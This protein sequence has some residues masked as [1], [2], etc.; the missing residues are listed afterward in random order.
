MDT[1][2]EVEK[3]V[4]EAEKDLSNSQTLELSG[5]PKVKEDI[6]ANTTE[7]FERSLKMPKKRIYNPK[8]KKYYSIRQK[9]TSK[10]KKGTIKGE[11]KPKRKAKWPDI[12]DKLFK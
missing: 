7:R 3:E 4:K 11:W 2:K 1:E 8:T 12:L 10:G 5:E 6:E 9:T